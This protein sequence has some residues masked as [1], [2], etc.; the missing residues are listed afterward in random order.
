M[1]LRLHS[2]SDLAAL[3]RGRSLSARELVGVSLSRIEELDPG[4]NAWAAVDGDR[5]LAEAAAIDGRLA[6]GEEVGPLAGIPIGVKDLEAAKGF[7]TAYGSAL[8]VDDAP[9]EAD[10]P[11]GGAAAGRRMRGRGQDHDPGVR[12]HR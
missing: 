5:A 6:A 10:S 3:V 1:D 2:L 7:V 12:I 8:H 9:A 11:F 4:L